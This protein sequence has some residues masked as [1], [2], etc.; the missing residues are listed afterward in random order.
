MS[1]PTRRLG[2]RSRPAI[3]GAIAAALVSYADASPA[4]G[5]TDVQG[6]IDALKVQST[7]GATTEFVFRPGEPAPAG[8]VFAS[9]PLLVAAARAKQIGLK[10]VYFDN[11]LAACVIPAGAWDF[12]SPT[13]F[14]GN[15][16]G[17]VG[18]GAGSQATP[19]TVDPGA[20]LVNVGDFCDV[21]ITSNAAANTAVITTAAGNAAFL[22][23][24]GTAIIQ[25]GAGSFIKQTAAG[26]TCLWLEGFAAFRTGV[27][28]VYEN[29]AAGNVLALEMFDGS[30]LQGSVLKGVAGG[31]YLAILNGAN[32]QIVTAQPALAGGLTIIL[33]ALAKQ[34]AYAPAVV[35]DWTGVAPTSVANALDRIAAKITPIP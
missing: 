31:T 6:A 1:D 19:V 28:P 33:L 20:T 3:F 10:V 9:W 18:A 22:F 32:P 11:T 15:W 7:P 17:R 21:V 23:R 29:T 16:K 24:G 5:A 25:A 34:V 2:E 8:D 13:S 4:L 26:T 12:L 14:V 35:G 30:G 27:G